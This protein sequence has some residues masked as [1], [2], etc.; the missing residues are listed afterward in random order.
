MEQHEG[1]HECERHR[2][3]RDTHD[4]ALLYL[5]DFYIGENSIYRI[6]PKQQLWIR[7][8][9]EGEIR[10]DSYSSALSWRA[11][12]SDAVEDGRRLEMMQADA[13]GRLRQLFPP[14]IV[15]ELAM[16][17]K[18][19]INPVPVVRL[20]HPESQAVMILTRSRFR[21]HAVD[22]LH[23]LSSVGPVY[24]P[25]WIADIMR[26]NTMLGLR[27]DR[28][29][30]FQPTLPIS[31]FIEAA[32]RTGRMLDGVQ[33]AR[34][35]F[36]ES[37]PRLPIPAPCSIVRKLFEAQF[38]GHPLRSQLCDITIYADLFPGKI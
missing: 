10:D 3:D 27:L 29:T 38:P 32:G 23:N 21:G 22:A 36:S 30:R 17:A 4:L 25:I 37:R 26:L 19:P 12:V 20:Y 34:F 18:A 6:K 1:H 33:L 5:S 2:I 28:D 7:Y 14:A 24:Q 16:N 9:T 31:C 13:P 35:A 15:R 8:A 11:M